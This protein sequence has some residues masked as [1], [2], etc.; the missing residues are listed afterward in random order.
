MVFEVILNVI[1]E[2]LG[3]HIVADFNSGAFDVLVPAI[4]I[5]VLRPIKTLPEAVA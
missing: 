2:V 1:Y 5:T 3:G 4:L